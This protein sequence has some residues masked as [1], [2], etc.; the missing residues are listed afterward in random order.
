MLLIRKSNSPRPSHVPNS[1]VHYRPPYW[2]GNSS[3]GAVFMIINTMNTTQKMGFNLTENWAIAA[4]RIYNVRDLWKHEHVGVA[5]R[6]WTVTLEPHDVAAL[7]M[8]DAGP[9]PA[10]ELADGELAPPCAWPWLALQCTSPNG[11]L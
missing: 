9:E 8:T 6:N 2:A 7:L 4:G 11:S 3:Y 10:D 5:V 1:L